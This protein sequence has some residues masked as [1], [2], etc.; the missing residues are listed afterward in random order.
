MTSLGERC[1]NTLFFFVYLNNWVVFKFVDGLL[2]DGKMFYRFLSQFFRC[3][4]LAY[5]FEP[6]PNSCVAWFGGLSYDLRFI[7]KR[8]RTQSKS[9]FDERKEG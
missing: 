6:R 4:L 3:M 7:N 5:S 2:L 1:D 9:Q 8:L